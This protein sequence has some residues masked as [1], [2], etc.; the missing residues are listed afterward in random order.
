MDVNE[1]K[2][3]NIFGATYTVTKGQDGNFVVNGPSATVNTSYKN[4]KVTFGPEDICIT[5]ENHEEEHHK[6]LV[7][8]ISQ[9]ALPVTVADVKLT[10][11][12]KTVRE[13]KIN[14]QE[15]IRVRYTLKLSDEY[16]DPATG[17][18][19]LGKVE[20]EDP[21]YIE[22]HSP[23]GRVTFYS[24][25]Y[26]E[27]GTNKL[28]GAETTFTPAKD[29][30]YFYTDTDGKAPYYKNN[31]IEHSDQNETGKVQYREY[32]DGD[33]IKGQNNTDTAENAFTPSVENGTVTH[34]LGNNGSMSI[35]EPAELEVEKV[36]EDGAATDE[37]NFKLTLKKNGV[38]YKNPL[39]VVKTKADG[40]VYTEP[41]TVEYADNEGAY[42]F[43]L[44]TGEKI[45]FK[46]LPA[47]YSYSVIEYGDNFSNKETYLLEGV[48]GGTAEYVDGKL[49]GASGIRESNK[50]EAVTFTNQCLTEL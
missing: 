2:D 15:P 44:V 20:A 33:V 17:Q 3:I 19:D 41:A 30:R 6:D 38:E 16:K 14:E 47:G 36:A 32:T 25:Y 42:A 26:Y 43:R 4:E 49:V 29:N 10:A 23:D 11:T 9:K 40:T 18:I 8:K 1:I 28:P 50:T 39:T 31:E 22:K 48:T 45:L 13:F 12:D 37:F 5:V 46:Y 21:G 7:V 24:N 35:P 34:S 27:E